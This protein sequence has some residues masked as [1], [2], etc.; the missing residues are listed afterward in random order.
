MVRLLEDAKSQLRQEK[1]RWLR[2]EEKNQKDKDILTLQI[3]EL[4][5]K[6]STSRM[7]EDDYVRT[8]EDM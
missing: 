5:V 3:R 1:D 7:R 2:L 4:R 8:I 6:L